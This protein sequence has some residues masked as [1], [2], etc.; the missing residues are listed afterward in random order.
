M[1]LN[2]RNNFLILLTALIHDKSQNCD[3]NLLQ[4]NPVKISHW[5]V[6]KSITFRIGDCRKADVI[7]PSREN[8]LIIFNKIFSDTNHHG[9]ECK[10]LLCI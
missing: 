9:N 7:P 10:L 1:K 3:K 5:N 8:Y 4:L 6:L 2:R